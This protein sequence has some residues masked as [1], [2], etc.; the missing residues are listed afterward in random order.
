MSSITTALGKGFKPFAEP[1]YARCVNLVCKTIEECRLAAN[2]P[3]QD[4]PDKDF[5]I[6]ALDLLS[7]IIQALNTEAEPLVASTNPPVVQFLSIC[8]QVRKKTRSFRDMTLTML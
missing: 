1:V 6:V 4:V 5:M 8:I 3:A 7:G 2:D